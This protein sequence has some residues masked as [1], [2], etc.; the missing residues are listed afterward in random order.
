MF[1]KGRMNDGPPFIL[2]QNV[3]GTE[4]SEWV[5]QFEANE[6]YRLRHAKNAT[7]VVHEI[8]SFHADDTVNLT[9]PKLQ[10]I[11]QR[12]M[13]MRSPQGMFIAIPH[14]HD[15]HWHVHICG[16]P[17]EYLTGKSIRM[18]RKD[19]QSLKQGIQQVQFN[20]YP[21]LSRSI[22]DHNPP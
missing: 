13:E 12:Y 21:E 4:V 8:L 18:S 11:T 3:K 6:Q 10:A 9:L 20:E 19:F 22:V 17:L 2:T 5:K 1:D 7:R 16:S 14:I 15:A